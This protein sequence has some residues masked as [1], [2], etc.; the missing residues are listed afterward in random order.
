MAPV[1]RREWSILVTCG[2]VIVGLIASW[3]LDHFELQMQ[4]DLT[5]SRCAQIQLYLQ[6]LQSILK[7]HGI[8]DPG[9]YQW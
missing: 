4:H 6:D 5:K 7:S 1:S 2:V 8:E 9:G 3:G